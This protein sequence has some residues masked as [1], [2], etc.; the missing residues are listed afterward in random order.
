MSIN[1]LPNELLAIVASV[2]N[3][4]HDLMAAARISLSFRSVFDEQ[5]FK[6]YG[7]SGL[8]LLWATA[9]GDEEA[10]Q[11]AID[12]GVCLQAGWPTK[13]R[14]LWK[15][16][17]PPWWKLFEAKLK[18]YSALHIVTELGR[19]KILEV[20][21]SAGA[22]VNGLAPCRWRCSDGPPVHAIQ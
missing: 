5:L 13:W 12:M 18:G 15:D 14:N 7:E 8:A 17:C 20:L 22:P 1:K 16:N 2:L 4:D 3:G 21:I 11:T 19:M 6:K 9:T 10:L